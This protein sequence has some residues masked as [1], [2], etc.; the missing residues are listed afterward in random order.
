MFQARSCLY[1]RSWRFCRRF[2]SRRTQ[3][4]Y[5]NGSLCSSCCWLSPELLQQELSSKLRMAAFVY[6][7]GDIRDKRVLEYQHESALQGVRG[8]QTVYADVLLVMFYLTLNVYCP[9]SGSLDVV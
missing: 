3:R 8:E 6:A 5:P 1:L 4:A 7:H 9:V 2:N